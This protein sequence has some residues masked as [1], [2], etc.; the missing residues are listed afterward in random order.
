MGTEENIYV[1]LDIQVEEQN[2]GRIIVELYKSIV[3]KTVENFRALCTGEKGVGRFGKRLQY[4]GCKFHRIVPMFMVQGGDFTNGD[5]TGGESI[6]GPRFDDE[7]FDLKHDAEGMLGMANCGPNTNNS[8]FYI[9]TVPCTHLDGRNVVFGRVVKGLNVIK[10]VSDMCKANDKPPLDCFISNCGELKAGMSWDISENDGTLDVY[11]PWPDDLDMLFDTI[12]QNEFETVVSNIKE[13]GNYFYNNNSFAK[14][15]RKYRKALRYM[16]WLHKNSKGLKNSK[17][18]R[19]TLLLNLA[20]VMLKKKQ[21]TDAVD[22]CDQVLLLDSQAGKAFYRRAQAR[23]GTR[24]F[25]L[26][27]Q[28]YAHALKFFPNDARIQEEMK[29]AKYNQINYLNEE[30]KLFTKMLK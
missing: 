1:Y 27:L 10:E 30:K 12:S 24:D 8:Q 14:S 15:E 7:N 3:P 26:A 5:G 17:C 21:Y 11:P 6:Y 19:K 2:M 9:T 20:M 25:D 13:S 18:L 22:F 4:K 23:M 28:D 29:R 16:D